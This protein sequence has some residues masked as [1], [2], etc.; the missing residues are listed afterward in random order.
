MSNNEGMGAATWLIAITLII[1]CVVTSIAFHIAGSADGFTLEAFDTGP[2][3]W[4]WVAAFGMAALSVVIVL[5]AIASV[6]VGRHR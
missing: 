6:E 3:T 1:V 4:W 5:M 2:S